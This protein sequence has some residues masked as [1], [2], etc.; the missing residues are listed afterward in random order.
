MRRALPTSAATPGSAE[1]HVRVRIGSCGLV[2]RP[3]VCAGIVNDVRAMAAT[4]DSSDPAAPMT[5]RRRVLRYPGVV[6]IGL[7][8]LLFDA[9]HEMATAALPGFLRSIGAPAAALGAIAGLADAA[10]SVSKVAGGL[11]PTGATSSAGP[12]PRA[13]TPSLPV[14]HG[15]FGPQRARVLDG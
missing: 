9:G 14:G 5:P 8:S 7:G 4:P 13:A 3:V 6:G 1:P 2:L 10:R 11:S 15:A 12:P